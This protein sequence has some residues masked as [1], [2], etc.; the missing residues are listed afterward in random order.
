MTSGWTSLAMVRLALMNSKIFIIAAA[1]L[2][3]KGFASCALF[4]CLY[5]TEKNS[6]S[7]GREKNQRIL[8][9]F[10]Y[11]FRA[12]KRDVR[13]VIV[14]LLVPFRI[15]PMSWKMSLSLSKVSTELSSSWS[16][17]LWLEASFSWPQFSVRVFFRKALLCVSPVFKEAQ[18]C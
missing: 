6:S 2:N 7:Q 14:M 5:K 12:K 3:I 15:S 4:L 13:A 16:F 18:L 17:F 11:G 9:V 8:N 10:F 1:L